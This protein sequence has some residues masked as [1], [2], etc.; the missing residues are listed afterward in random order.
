MLQM[1][2]PAR[3]LKSVMRL[4][5]KSKGLEVE[6]E[7]R[8]GD[9]E[10]HE[11]SDA[12]RSMRVRMTR[13]KTIEAP[14]KS[15]QVKENTGKMGE[16]VGRRAQTTSS[17]KEK[18]LRRGRKREGEGDENIDSEGEDGEGGE[19]DEE[20]SGSEETSGSGGGSGSGSGSESE[21]GS[22]KEDGGG[23]ANEGNNEGGEGEEGQDSEKVVGARPSAKARGK[24][25][26]GLSDKVAVDDMSKPFLGGPINQELLT[27]FNNHVAA[28]IWNKKSSPVVGGIVEVN[29]RSMWGA[30]RWRKNGRKGAPHPANHGFPHHHCRAAAVV[31]ESDP[32]QPANDAP[33]V[34]AAVAVSERCLLRSPC[35]FPTGSARKPRTVQ[36][37]EQLHQALNAAPSA[38]RTY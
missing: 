29:V 6:E 14:K 34:V 21:Y 37:F 30:Q 23:S 26:S 3:R 12:D 33:E 25:K 18:E 11:G 2:D 9:R 35:A 28:A 27:S 8:S 36:A 22:T 7:I 1:R 38:P 17:R 13:T 4:S 19:G 15:E 32:S 5:A 20:G 10:E 24:A 31:N 16:Q